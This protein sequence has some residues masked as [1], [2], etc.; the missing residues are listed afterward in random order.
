MFE[1]KCSSSNPGEDL[2]VYVASQAVEV[3]EHRHSLI[4]RLF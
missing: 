4:N 1:W 3:N 2:G